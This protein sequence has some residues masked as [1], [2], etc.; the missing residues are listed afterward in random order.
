[1][2]NHIYK[3]VVFILFTGVLVG[4]EPLEAQQDSQYT[5]Y[6]YNTVTVNP[7]Y[8]GTRGSLSMTGL[9]RNQWVGLEGAPETLN[10]SLNSPIGIQGVGLG[11]SFTSDK[12]GPSSESLVTADFSYTIPVSEALNLSFGIKAGLSIFD[13]DPNKLTI[14]NPNDYDLSR[15]NSSSPVAGLGLYLHSD[16]WYMGLSTPN[17]LETEHYDEVQVSTATEKLHAYF[18]G[19]YVFDLNE[20]LKLK[21]AVLVKAVSGAP[22]AVD[23]SANALINNGLILGLA[24]RLDAAV[25]G[26]AGFQLSD[27]LMIG[28]AY[29]Y[30]T[31]DLSRYNSGSHEIFLRFE[32]GTRFR[33]KVNPR[34]F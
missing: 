16:R 13:L 17:L 10:F 25:S 21:P 27:N 32:L 28:Y 7:A 5:Q 34:F 12:L 4:F 20:S 29:D 26:M 11:F 23:L 31:T 18:I 24:Y 8:A 14:Y 3:I 6:M 9:Y 22:L 15:K 30:E 33:G 19:G 1:M 2:H